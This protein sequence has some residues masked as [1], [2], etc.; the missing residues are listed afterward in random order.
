M[1]I[2]R[3]IGIAVMCRCVCVCVCLVDTSHSL[4]TLAWLSV[5]SL[6]RHSPTAGV[7]AHSCRVC[8]HCSCINAGGER[9]V[10][11]NAKTMKW[12][13]FVWN[14]NVLVLFMR[15]VANWLHHFADTHTHTETHR[16]TYTCS[17][18]VFLHECPSHSLLGCAL[19]CDLIILSSEQ[20]FVVD[21]FCCY[22]SG[23]YFIARLLLSKNLNLD[24][25]IN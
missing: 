18:F 17:Y 13:M 20:V 24:N 2:H 9:C 25:K 6:L 11:K 14:L 8:V 12:V 4:Q 1:P 23:V 22:C 21:L 7:I 5:I 16:L 3:Q 19:R 15:R 10:G